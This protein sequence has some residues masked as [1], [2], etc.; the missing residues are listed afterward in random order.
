MNTDNPWSVDP[1]CFA[2]AMTAWRASLPDERARNRVYDCLIDIS[3]DPLRVG[4][5]EEDHPGVFWVRVAGTDV[6][7]LYTVD[8]DSQSICLVSVHPVD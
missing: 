5:E 8:V 6:G 3:R 4:R 1:D 2:R 7:V